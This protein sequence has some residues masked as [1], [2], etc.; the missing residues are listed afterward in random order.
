MINKKHQEL[1]Q[2][3]QQQ[4]LNPN[5]PIR[6]KNHLLTQH[7]QPTPKNN[8]LPNTH[9]EH[10]FLEKTINTPTPKFITYDN[11]NKILITITPQ[12]HHSTQQDKNDY[13]IIESF[14]HLTTQLQKQPTTHLKQ[15]THKTTTE[16][17]H[18][19]TDNLHEIIKNNR[20][21]HN[22]YWKNLTVN[23]NMHTNFY[24]KK[25]SPR[26]L[27]IIHANTNRQNIIIEKN[28]N[29]TYTNWNTITIGD[30]L[31][32]LATHT[33]NMNYLKHQEEHLIAAWRNRKLTPNMY[34]DYKT[35]KQLLTIHHTITTTINILQDTKQN[36]QNLIKNSWI[37]TETLNNTNIK[38]F[39]KKTTFQKTQQTLQ[40][41]AVYN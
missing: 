5:N 38:T 23:P 8:L 29:I 24:H 33:H 15:P 31:F 1:I 25:L 14:L 27:H 18:H 11:K 7:P 35:Y 19:L 4:G 16:F 36:P 34:E 2:Q 32:E 3:A 9:Q 6:I 17:L 37:L 12:P 20:M 39:N 21:K 22:E 13:I 28:E 10:I 30:P 26:K 40:K 41:H